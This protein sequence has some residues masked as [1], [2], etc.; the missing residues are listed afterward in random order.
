ME[1]GGGRRAEGREEERRGR[2]RRSTR[3]EGEHRG[4]GE[5]EGGG[6]E[7]GRN[8]MMGRERISEMLNKM[9][10]D[11]YC[12]TYSFTVVHWNHTLS[13]VNTSP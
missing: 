7:G 13:P 10:L 9:H 3:S 5:K 1:E 6:R 8:K 4:E 2:W 11:K 12:V